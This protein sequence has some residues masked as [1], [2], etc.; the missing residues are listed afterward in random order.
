MS[1]TPDTDQKAV[2]HIGF[3]SCA[4]VPANFARKLKY[5]RDE[6]R[7][8]AHS[9][10]SLYYAKSGINKGGC[11]FPWEGDEAREQNFKLCDSADTAIE[12]VGHTA[13]Q[14][15]LL[16]ELKQETP[17]TDAAV[18]NTTLHDR[19]HPRIDWVPADFARKLERERDEARAA[20]M[21][22]EDL[23]I[24][25][26]DIYA[27]R[28]NMGLIARNALE[29][30]ECLPAE[31]GRKLERERDEAREAFKEMWRS[32]DAFLPY[33]DAETINRWRK[34]AGWEETK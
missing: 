1:D 15:K 16:A 21:K 29:G 33:V 28:E 8:A 23:F 11:A 22:I 5:E 20:L 14:Q 32:G 31:F 10:R 6:A 30:A 24:D 7:E 17:Q 18:E 25:G 4:T 26:T 13:V 2:P 9:F 3:Y 12:Y 34:A 27:D 19:N